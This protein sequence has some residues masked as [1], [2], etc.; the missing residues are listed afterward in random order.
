MPYKIINLNIEAEV[1][2]KEVEKFLSLERPDFFCVQEVTENIFLKWKQRF[3]KDAFFAPMVLGFNEP[4][5]RWGLAIFSMYKIS[6]AEV[7]TYDK[8]KNDYKEFKGTRSE[9][10]V[11]KLLAVD[12][13]NIDNLRIATTHF[14]WCANSIV[15]Y[16]QKVNVNYLI[17]IIKNYT[18][19]ILTGD[20]NSP[21][22]EYVFNNLSTIMK[23]NTP[24]YWRT[25]LDPEK[26]RSRGI[27]IVVDGIFSKGSYKLFDVR[28]KFGVSDHCAI[29]AKIK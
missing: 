16:Q 9:R 7:I 15:S 27:N 29:V 28:Q 13:E 1:N 3:F 24:S 12:F 14:T 11:A 22:G 23:D 10:P 17:S 8:F 4:F 26:H 6:S 18:N 25:T 21:R 5:G 2:I 20:F 19:L